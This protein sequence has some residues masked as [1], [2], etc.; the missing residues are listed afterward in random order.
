MKKLILIG[1]ILAFPVPHAFSQAVA[2]STLYDAGLA[3]LNKAQTTNNY[4]EAAFYFKQMTDQLPG[5]WPAFYY[6]GLA[7]L[8]ASQTALDSKYKDELIDKAQPMID[9]AF[10]IRSGESEL[11]ALQAFLYQTRLQVNPEVR[12]LSFS[13]KADASLK[14]AVAANPSN[15][16]AYMLMGYNTYYTPVLFGGGAK[17][18]LSLF[19][20]AREKYHAFKPEL[21]YLPSW[22]LAEN[23]QMIRECNQAPK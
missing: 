7:Y 2:D 5:Q 18:A 8:R 21:P 17:K 1:F 9:K 22:G 23:Q 11:H 3:L 15:P 4:L 16:R 20:K 10:A 6:A 19:L 13:Q 12:A 14:K